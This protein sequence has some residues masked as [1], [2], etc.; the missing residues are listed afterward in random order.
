[1]GGTWLDGHLV[2]C[3]VLQKTYTLLVCNVTMFRSGPGLKALQEDPLHFAHW[4]HSF[5]IT[6]H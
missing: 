6:P 3:M 5:H 2:L 1:M 4:S